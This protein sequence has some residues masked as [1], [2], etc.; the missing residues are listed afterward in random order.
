MV[1]VWWL[2]RGKEASFVLGSRGAFIIR[3][4]DDLCIPRLCWLPAH[5]AYRALSGAE[6]NA[7][8]GRDHMSLPLRAPVIHEDQASTTIPATV[9]P[10]PQHQHQ[11]QEEEDDWAISGVQSWGVQSTFSLNEDESPDCTR[12]SE[13]Q[14][15]NDSPTPSSQCGGVP[16]MGRKRMSFTYVL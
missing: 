11:Q 3:H 1:G 14:G 13:H 12:H 8:L 6:G 9:D 16:S 5:T 10:T 7:K 15:V 2:R 4:A